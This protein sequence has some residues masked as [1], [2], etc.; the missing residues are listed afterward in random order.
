MSI[1]ELAVKRKVAT[2][3]IMFVMFCAGI[4]AL[5]N[6]KRELLPDFS[7]PVVVVRTTWNGA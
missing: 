2:I 6:M 3:M 4:L 7:F 1:A 5:N